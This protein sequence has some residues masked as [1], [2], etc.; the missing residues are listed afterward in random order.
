MNKTLTATF[1]SEDALKA[2]EYN[3][4]NAEIAGIPRE[5][6]FVDKEKKEIKVIIPTAT[7]AEIRSI[8]KENNPK[9]I[10]EREWKH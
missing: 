9:T 5:K 6:I 10:T 2:A 7:E 1:E 3:I 4:I 8:L